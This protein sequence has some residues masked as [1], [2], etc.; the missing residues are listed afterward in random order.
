MRCGVLHPLTGRTEP[1]TYA[2]NHRPQY[3]KFLDEKGGFFYE[4]WG[5]G[6]PL[7]LRHRTSAS[8]C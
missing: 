4:R 3:F 8:G 1:G 7:D 2:R 6:K 5:D